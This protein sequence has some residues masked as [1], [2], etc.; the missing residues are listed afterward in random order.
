MDVCVTEG[1]MGLFD[2]F[3]EWREAVRLLPPY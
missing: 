2:G 1:V 3:D